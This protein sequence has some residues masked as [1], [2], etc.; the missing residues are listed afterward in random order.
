MVSTISFKT[1][2]IHI[3]VFKLNPH[4]KPKFSRRLN[5]L[6]ELLTVDL[7]RDDLQHTYSPQ[8]ENIL[9]AITNETM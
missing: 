1:K 6:Y 3:L 7:K 4:Y 9:D 5:L 8:G 2:N